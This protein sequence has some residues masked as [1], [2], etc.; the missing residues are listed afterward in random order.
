M[1]DSQKPSHG[2]SATFFVNGAKQREGMLLLYPDKLIAVKT[3]SVRAWIYVLVPAVYLAVYYALYHTIGWGPLAIWYLAGW[4]A[5][6]AI[7]KKRAAR[8]VAAGGDGVTVIP[9]DQ[10]TSVRS[11]K[12]RKAARWLGMRNMTVTTADGT[13]Y[14]FD[15]L[16]EQWHDHLAKALTAHGREVHVAAGTITVMPRA[17]LGES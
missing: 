14:R 17:T 10:V 9:L 3:G 1:P 12:G 4:W 2:Q 13:E 6:Q 11:R 7:D 5:W 16:M 15:G 8:K